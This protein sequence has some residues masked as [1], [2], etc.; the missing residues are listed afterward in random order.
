M[1]VF[2]I[3]LKCVFIC[4]IMTIPCCFTKVLKLRP[5]NP[6]YYKC[7]CNILIGMAF[8]ICNDLRDA[9]KEGKKERNHYPIKLTL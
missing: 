3:Y 2:Y 6:M 1:F 7:Y 9:K 4:Y 8:I 5:L